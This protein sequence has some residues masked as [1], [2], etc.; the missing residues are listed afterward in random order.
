MMSDHVG[1]SVFL[2]WFEMFLEE[3][4]DFRVAEY[5]VLEF[6]HVVSFVFKD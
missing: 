5:F 6:Y 3:F 4:G 1:G 2:S